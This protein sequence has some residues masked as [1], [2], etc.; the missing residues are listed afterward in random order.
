MGLYLRH[1]GSLS[2]SAFVLTLA[3]CAEVPA[4]PVQ[5]S[6]VLSPSVSISE[7]PYFGDKTTTGLISSGFCY[8]FNVTAPDLMNPNAEVG[9]DSC[10]HGPT[11][12]GATF[13][14][15]SYRKTAVLNLSPGQAR[16]FDLL[17]FKIPDGTSQVCEDGKLQF[18][19]VNDG[20]GTEVQVKYDGIEIGK[21]PEYGALPDPDKDL[22]IFSR[23]QPVTLTTGAQTVSMTPI[24]YE[25]RT[26]DGEAKSFPKRYDCKAYTP[27]KLVFD[28]EIVDFGIVTSIQFKDVFVKNEGN[29]AAT[30]M[31]GNSFDGGLSLKYATG[32]YPGNNDTDRCQA[33]LEPGAR[34]RLMLKVVHDQLTPGSAPTSRPLTMNYESGNGPLGATINVSAARGGAVGLTLSRSSIDFGSH[35]TAVSM[36]VVLTN[37]SGATITGFQFNT[38]PLSTPFAQEFN[39]CPP[40][41][42]NGASCTIRLSFQGQLAVPG[43][44]NGGTYRL[45]Y[46]SGVMNLPLTGSRPAAAPGVLVAQLPSWAFSTV[47]EVK[48]FTFVNGGVST[49]K[50]TSIDVLPSSNSAFD[51]Y[52]LDCNPNMDLDAA[53]TCFFDMKYMRPAGTNGSITIYYESL[54]V[55]RTPV[56]VTFTKP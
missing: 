54:G 29:V 22:Y 44:D 25:E 5:V 51:T 12:L 47:N 20:G 31:E 21:D 32:T 46:N 27:A 9:E 28:P 7:N 35:D 24:E 37:N 8:F 41:L 43:S 17:G 6:V 50:I 19:V 2:L 36:N 23:S 26:I 13:G 18:V 14:A 10:G 3:A 1:V 11:G 15:Y 48:R 30:L 56:T 16:R 42:A 4:P 34:C 39:G 49:L 38:F 55:A 53:G 40:D 52:S 45:S 33:S